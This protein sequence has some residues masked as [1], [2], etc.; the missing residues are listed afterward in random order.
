VNQVIPGCKDHQHEDKGETDPEA[1]FLS[2]F[3]QGP[4]PDPLYAVEEKKT[5]IEH[6]YRE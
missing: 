4:A 1:D 2:G 5:A 6:M 3:A